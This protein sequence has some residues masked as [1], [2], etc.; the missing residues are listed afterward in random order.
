MRYTRN[1]VS[2]KSESFI[3]DLAL[4]KHCVIHRI[5]DKKAGPSTEQTKYTV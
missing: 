2:E 1:I 5:H 4:F 3:N